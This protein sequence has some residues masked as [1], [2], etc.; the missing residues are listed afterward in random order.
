[1]DIKLMK[2]HLECMNDELSVDLDIYCMEHKQF[3]GVE[4]EAV[5]KFVNWLIKK[6]KQDIIEPRGPKN[7]SYED[8]AID[9]E[10]LQAFLEYYEGAKS[11]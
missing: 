9:W 11:T 7:K 5:L 1:V 6:N 2:H 8:W 4:F 10:D 3:S